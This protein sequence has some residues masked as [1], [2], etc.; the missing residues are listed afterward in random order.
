M[1]WLLAACDHAQAPPP[2]ALFFLPGGAFRFSIG[3]L[4]EFVSFGGVFQGLPGILVPSLVVLF[5][6]VRRG[7][8]VCVC[9]KIVELRG[10]LVCVF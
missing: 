7:N 5:A 2:Q 1:R 3:F 10:S 8:T 4:C 9:R 6:M